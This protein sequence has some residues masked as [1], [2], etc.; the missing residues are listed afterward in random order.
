MDIVVKMIPV[1]LLK[2]EI[3]QAKNN[4]VFEYLVVFQGALN[5][6]AYEWPNDP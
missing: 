1:I 2:R 4:P 6:V 3:M 5:I